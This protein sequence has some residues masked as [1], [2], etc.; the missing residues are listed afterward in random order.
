MTTALLFYLA[1]Y[2]KPL[3]FI[4]H[5]Q[6][7]HKACSCILPLH[8]LP[9]PMLP[10]LGSAPLGLQLLGL[11]PLVVIELRFYQVF[12]TTLIFQGF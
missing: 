12:T 6:Q 11:Q 3:H 10:F 9:V 2:L 8:L 1:S 4:R 7:K 5:K